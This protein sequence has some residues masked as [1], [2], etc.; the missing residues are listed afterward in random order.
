MRVLVT[1][2]N[3]FIGTALT[4]QLLEAGIPF[5]I[6]ERDSRGADDTEKVTGVKNSLDNSPGIWRIR[7]PQ[8]LSTL[9]FKEYSS[10][11]HLAIARP[12]SNDSIEDAIAAQCSPLLEL[13]NGI[14]NSGATCGILFMSSQS[15][16]RLAVSGYGR[17]KW[18]AEQLLRASSI[19]WTIIQPGL[20]IGPSAKGLFAGILSLV[21]R[22]PVVPIPSGGPM[23]IQP[24]LLSDIIAA[25]LTIV[26]NPTQHHGHYYKLALPRRSFM[27]FIEEMCEALDLSRVLIPIP[28]QAISWALR[29]SELLPF[30]LP[31]SRSNL[32]GLLGSQEL[33]SEDSARKLELHL[34]EPCHDSFLAKSTGLPN[35]LRAEAQYIF[36]A[37]FKQAAP[38]EVVK[39][40]V[41]AQNG[42][43]LTGAWID[44]PT[45]VARRLDLDAIEF[46]VR[47]RKTI[48]SQKLQI[49]CY[50]AELSPGLL[51]HFINK[52]QN[53][54]G[55]YMA[56][57]I[58]GIRSA[59]SF[60]YGH[61]LVI[62]FKLFDGVG[63]AG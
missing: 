38:Q 24:V 60:L 32:E 36:Q 1:G 58:A 23:Q 14:T 21:K 47:R 10:V 40:Y 63:H 8:G 28:W 17:G 4:A 31:V 26:R 7:W 41:A 39:Y 50:I 51:N 9:P 25:C 19:A 5:D 46:A 56:L 27:K 29:L 61:Y 30:K 49:M 62:R 57:A 55:A 34:S 52:R 45:I 3:G 43:I 11:V 59:V 48:L 18:E 20:I 42:A 35:E 6:V 2:S 22:L 12:H 54:L 33:I 37:L 15:A 53:R 44:M 13:I 16:T